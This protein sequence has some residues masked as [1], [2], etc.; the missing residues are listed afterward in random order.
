MVIEA[1]K[2]EAGR[3]VLDRFHHLIAADIVT[4]TA[5]QAHAAL[6]TFRR[7]GRRR[8]P[9]GRLLFKGDDFARTDIPPAAQS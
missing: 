9:A 4:V 7:F 6:D 2:C 8:H 1:H 5:E 3:A